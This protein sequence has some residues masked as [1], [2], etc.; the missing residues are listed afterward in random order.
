MHEKR[1]FRSDLNV[2]PQAPLFFF[3]IASKLLWV[4]QL[5]SL[6]RCYC[7]A[8]I[9]LFSSLLCLFFPLWYLSRRL[10]TISPGLV[11]FL[12]VSVNLISFWACIFENFIPPSSL[13]PHFCFSV[14]S[15]FAH[16]TWGQKCFR[17]FLSLPLR[18]SC[19]CFH[20][21]KR[22]FEKTVQEPFPVLH[23][24]TERRGKK[25]SEAVQHKGGCS[26]QNKIYMAGHDKS[27]RGS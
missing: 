1:D 5:V 16:D 10:T 2:V 18:K 13:P 26:L 14:F 25:Q 19:C 8:V 22:E 23:I 3:A 17:M 7:L 20:C 15:N 4:F 11:P 9:C 24:S 21:G 27:S 6:K 12:V